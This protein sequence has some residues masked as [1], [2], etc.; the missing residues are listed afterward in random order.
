MKAFDGPCQI[1]TAWRK[2]RDELMAA[3][4]MGKRPYAFWM[5]ERRLNQRPAGEAGELRLIKQ[6]DLYRDAA[7]KEFVQKRL[8]VITGELRSRWHC[9]VA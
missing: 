6:L 1:I 8:A 5:V 4:P 9:R 2:H 3:C 7:E